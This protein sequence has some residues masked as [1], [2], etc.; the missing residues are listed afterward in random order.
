MVLFFTS[1]V[2]CPPTSLYMG[3][4][5][6]ENEVLLKYGD[7]LDVWFH[8]DKLSSAHVYLRLQE[9]MKWEEIPK[10]LLEDIGQL[11]KANSIEGNKKQTVTI[12]YTPWSNVKKTGDLATGAVQFHNDRIV[13]RHHIAAKDNA[14]L[15][16]LNKTKREELVD[17]EAVRQER[18]RAKGRERKEVAVKER[19]AKLAEQRAR[20]EAKA[21]QDYSNPRAKA[22]EEKEKSAAGDDAER[23]GVREEQSEEEDAGSEGSFM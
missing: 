3:K 18:E 23:I 14:I 11:T 10:T 9:D 5:K 20:Q 8:V 12:I 4:D 15:N 16:R 19:N 2:T 22:Q 6:F 21:S 13:R 1:T 7:E 17:H